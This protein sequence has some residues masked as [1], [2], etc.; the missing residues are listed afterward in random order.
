MF[1]RFAP[2]MENRDEFAEVG[3]EDGKSGKTSESPADSNRAW[4]AMLVITT[5][6]TMMGH[7]R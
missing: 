1:S 7:V 2:S 3:A 6:S 4:S 5:P